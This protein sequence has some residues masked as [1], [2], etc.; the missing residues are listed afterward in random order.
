M[1]RSHATVTT[2]A[3]LRLRCAL[4]SKETSMDFSFQLYSARNFPPMDGVLAR[5]AALGYTQVEGFGGLYGD[6]DNLAASLKQHGLNMPTGHFGLTQ[7]QDSST[8]MQV[9]ERLGIKTLFCPAIP[10]EDRGQDEGKWVELADTL[11]ELGEIYRRAGFCFGWHNHDFEFV[12]T[13]SGRLPMDIL[14]DGAPD[15]E[16]EM[17]VAWAVSGGQDPLP[18]LQ[19]YGQRI[20][21]VHVKD[22][23]PAGE[24]A[25]EDG[26]ADVGHG[27]MDWEALQAAIRQHTRAK[28]FVMEHDNP[29]DVDR[30]AARSLAA[31][32]DWN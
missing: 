28:Y 19:K 7:L 10:R 24:A 32:R 17:D 15:N 12:P 26:W 16:W 29:S 8:S 30:F 27:T 5:L 25:D 21:A 4:A 14:L 6:V 11:A 23:A 31:V 1:G 20:T 9:A 13:A 3:R 2:S 22:I 18:W